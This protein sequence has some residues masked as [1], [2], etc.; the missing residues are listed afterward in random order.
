MKEKSKGVGPK[1]T[2]EKKTAADKKLAAVKAQ[3]SKKPVKA[4]TDLAGGGQGGG[5]VGGQGALGRVKFTPRNGAQTIVDFLESVGVDTV[6]GYPG[7]AV[8][9][10]YDALY[11]SKIKHVLTRHEQAAAHA[12]DGY[13]RSTGKPGVVFATSGPGATNLVTGLATA[14]MDSVPMLAITGQVSTTSLGSDSFQEADIYGISIPIT[15]YNY[16]VKDARALPGILSE[17]YRLTDY[18]RPGP[19]LVDVPKDIQTTIV[20]PD[21][22]LPDSVPLRFEKPPSPDLASVDSL[23]EA[24]HVSH[25]PVLY[26]G[27]GATITNSGAD[28]LTLVERTDMAV[29]A[30]LQAK[31]VFPDNHPLCLGIPGMHGSKYANL[32]INESDLILGLGVRFDDRVVG[33][34]RRFAPLARVVHVDIDPAEIGKRLP[35]DVAVIGDLGQ[36][37]SLVLKRLPKNSRPA[38]RKRV[39]E[40]RSTFPMDVPQSS[41][42]IKPQAAIRALSDSCKGQAILV[43]DVGQH[44]MWAAQYFQAQKPRHFLSSGGLGTMGFGLPAAIG[45]QL[46]N[47][48]SLVCLIV[49]DGGF[50]MNVQELATIAQYQVPIKIMLINNGCLGM[51]RQWQ[52]FFFNRRYSQT[53]FD[54]NP[55]FVALAKVYGLWAESV[56]KSDKVTQMVKALISQKGPALLDVRVPRDE[57]VLPMI[58]AGMGQ[59]DF[60]ETEE[61]AN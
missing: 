6:F 35:V 51:V 11:D 36:V 45:A 55:D 19:V 8:I 10:L 50:Q 24:L 17:A 26:L 29:V 60:F 23:I 61:G 38:W 1:K 31:G 28:I 9:P 12:A 2:A 52:Q 14:H 18:G 54:Y 7:G 40:L 21:N 41:R 59:T 5:Q 30:T 34:V 43:T 56:E 44:Q 16:L 33:N 39:A 32:A 37:L 15:K 42:E 48:K 25:R 20:N 57:N 27:G 4:K 49:G 3:A 46:A 13:A 22:L 53:L 58:P 47:P